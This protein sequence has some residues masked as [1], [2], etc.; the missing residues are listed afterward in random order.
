MTPS[1]ATGRRRPLASNTI[2]FGSGPDNRRTH[3]TGHGSGTPST[4]ECSA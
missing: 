4:L 1:T 3:V 2:G